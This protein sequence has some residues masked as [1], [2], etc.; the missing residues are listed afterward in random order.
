MSDC[1]VAKYGDA[2][3]PRYTSYPTA[4]AFSAAV[5]PDEYARGLA[6]IGKAGPVSVY[7][8]V[9]FCRSMC[10]YCGCHTSIT[11]QD[12]PVREYLDVMSQ[13]IE[14][15][16]FAAGNE[17]PVKN[18]HFG[19][20]TPTIMR[21]QEFATVMAKLR[22]AFGFEA[23]A[24]IA[25]EID[26]RTLTAPMIE[27]LG[28]SG[29]D[30]VSLGVQSFDPI[31]QATI[32]R[33]QSFERTEIAVSGLR[34]VGISSINFDLIYGLP[35]QTL[36]SCIETVRLAVQ[37]RPERFAVFGYAHIPAFK[38]HQRLIDEASLPD[39]KQ[40]NEQAEAIAEEL[41]KAGYERIGLDHF[42]LPDDQLAVAARNGTMRRNF[43]GYTTDDCNT[44]IGLGASAIGRLPTGYIQNHVPLGLYQERVASGILPTAKGYLLTEEDKLR[45][46]IIE[47]LMCDFEVDLGP[48]SKESSFD[49]EFLIGRN[50]RL[51][52]LIDDG[53]AT[54]SGDRIVVSQDA[55]FMVRAVAAAFDAYFGSHGRT[56]S[57]AA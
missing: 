2:R 29:V 19:G 48:L 39:A 6:N 55:R 56:H 49:I 11:R 53:V 42:A 54:I 27:A 28:E 12:G 37:L 23:D 45:A 15:V 31:V 24:S 52:E 30:R 16:S 22:S 26:P 40:R 17:V 1:L 5:G 57:K 43:Q 46:R 14:L 25:V 9:P 38:K 3:F 51:G 4:P 44:L 32:N 41:V 18:V 8:H 36:Q 35:K 34:S 13:E 21:P 33:M 47:R 10:W 7:L 50:D 20:G